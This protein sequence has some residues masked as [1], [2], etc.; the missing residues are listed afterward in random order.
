MEKID[1]LEMIRDAIEVELKG[2]VNDLIPEEYG[3]MRLLLNYHMG[4]EEGPT[5]PAARG[6]RIRPA[7]VCLCTSAAGGDW[8][9]ALPA[10]AAV[11]L[12]H[13]FSLIHDDIQ[14]NSPLR[15]GKD[16]VWVKW[17]IAQA[18]NAG[19]LMFT[20]AFS[21]L[22]R[23][24]NGIPDHLALD[25]QQILTDTCIQLTG[26][27]HLDLAYEQVRELPVDAYWPMIGGKTAALV[28]CACELGALAAQNDAEQR[29]AF[30]E[31]GKKIG[32]AFQ[33]QD[34]WLGIWG[35][36][37]QTG[38]S[39]ESDLVSGK[40]TLPV[41]FALQKDQEFARRWRNGPIRPDE[42]SQ[43]AGL[44]EK[45]GAKAFTRDCADQLTTEALQA[46]DR[47]ATHA[48]GKQALV[49]MA[50]SLLNREN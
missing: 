27:Q 2:V 24:R 16:T 5:G 48:A 1:D 23:L 3:A 12:I 11:E 8:R 49:Q 15:H 39:T 10:A 43:M 13:N 26:G 19:D 18:I 22:Q 45:E 44:L 46:L 7:L 42:V 20:L 31:F 33:V 38:K 14:D 17:G 36:I 37:T 30:R 50:N 40:K 9:S 4:W 35:N 47:A 32:L 34:D 41:V 6:K 21:A 29:L 28:A 25:A